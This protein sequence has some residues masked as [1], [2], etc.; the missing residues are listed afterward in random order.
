MNIRQCARKLVTDLHV[1][2]WFTAAARNYVI[3]GTNPIQRFDYRKSS[4]W[5]EW[6]AR[7]DEDVKSA[8]M[9][10]VIRA[11]DGQIEQ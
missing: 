5:P 10:A 8:C 7:D 1:L 6:A 4:L 11:M 3:S 9:N 2:D